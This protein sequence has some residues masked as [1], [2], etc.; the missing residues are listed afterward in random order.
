MASSVESHQPPV[1]AENIQDAATTTRV[2]D[3]VQ[4]IK[5]NVTAVGS[6]AAKLIASNTRKLSSFHDEVRML[7]FE[8]ILP[9]GEK[10]SEVINQT[11]ENVKY[12]PGIK[13][14]QNVVVDLNLEN[15]VHEEHM[16]KACWEDK[17]RW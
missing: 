1:E 11:N 6:V 16:Q 8:E 14:R 15:A 2:E 17:R 9:A 12:L 7:V 10:L 4:P 13:L 3:E 5:S